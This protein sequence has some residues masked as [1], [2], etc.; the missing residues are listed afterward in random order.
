M[1]LCLIR[2]PFYALQVDKSFLRFKG[3]NH[4]FSKDLHSNDHGVMDKEAKSNHVLV[5]KWKK[6]ILKLKAWSSALDF[7][8]ILVIENELKLLVVL[9]P[10]I[11]SYTTIPATIF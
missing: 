6:I 4:S 1:D 10:T 5:V 11:F 8:Y 2:L 9:W 7:D 3:Y